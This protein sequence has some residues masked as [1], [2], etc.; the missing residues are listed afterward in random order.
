ML[1]EIDLSRADLN[2]LVLFDTVL[3]ER[4]VGR[5]AEALNLTPSAVSH[6]LG[7]LRRML[8]DPLFLKTPRGVA[9]TDRALALAE[10]VAEILA[11][12]RAVV[13][14]AAPFDPATSER[15]FTIGAP[16]GALVLLLDRFLGDLATSAPGIDLSLRHVLPQPK[17]DPAA[18]W[19]EVLADL[20]SRALDLAVLPLACAPARFAVR[21]VLEEDFVA[22]SRPDHPFATEPSL[23]RFCAA[24]HLLVSQSGDRQ[25][26]VD[27]ALAAYGLSRRVAVTVPN[28]SMA[29]AVL[30]ETG[31]I[32]ALPRRFAARH[33]ARYGLV[34][35]ELPIAAGRG[36]LNAI[37]PRAALADAG[38]AFVLDRL[39][40]AGQAA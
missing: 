2:L 40:A 27:M 30:A 8:G 7:R 1:N 5:A 34:L 11:R 26:F 3:R 22:V 20:D 31:M 18:V 12:V 15:R 33:A 4:H 38:L 25:G 9:P 13:A 6:G 21:P 28:F 10:P 16:D 17:A 23:E 29:P 14:T 32:A 36:W 19:D 37:L 39:C 35:I 24:K